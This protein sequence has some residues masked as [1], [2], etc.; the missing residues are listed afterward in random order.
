MKFTV[1]FDISLRSPEDTHVVEDAI[2]AALETALPE[3]LATALD[4]DDLCVD[5]CVTDVGEGD[6]DDADEDD[7]EEDFDE[8]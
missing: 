7:E 1:T 5:V 3:A 8:D 6:S 4:D 2:I